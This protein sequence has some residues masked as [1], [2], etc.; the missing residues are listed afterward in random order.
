[1]S[2]DSPIRDR[3]PP[4]QKALPSPV[5]T[6]QRTERS[7][8]SAATASAN[9][10]VRSPVMALRRSGSVRV[11]TTTPSSWRSIR[12][13]WSLIVT[14]VSVARPSVV[15]GLFTL[16]R[17]RL[18]RVFGRHRPAY[19]TEGGP[20]GRHLRGLLR[21]VQREAHLRGRGPRERLRPSHGSGL[22]PRLRH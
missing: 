16:T 11:S 21:E 7:G 5:T 10:L 6:T 1:M 18:L 14:T 19:S 3:S 9:A 8:R 2:G 20:H 13:G 17:I 15:P 22:V 12:R 4:A